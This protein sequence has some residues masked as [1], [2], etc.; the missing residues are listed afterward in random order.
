MAL[1]GVRTVVADKE[2][3]KDIQSEMCDRFVEHI[4]EAEWKEEIEETK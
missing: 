3:I 1:C 2:K 4:F